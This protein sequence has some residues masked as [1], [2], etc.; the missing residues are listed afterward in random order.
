[1]WCMSTRQSVTLPDPLREYLQAV[2]DKEGITLSDMI[3]RA[4]A[5]WRARHEKENRQ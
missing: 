1:M 3:R 4:L 2:A 5:E